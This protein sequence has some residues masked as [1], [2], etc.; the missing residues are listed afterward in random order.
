MRTHLVT[1]SIPPAKRDTATLGSSLCLRNGTGVNYEDRAKDKYLSLRYFWSKVANFSW[2]SSTLLKRNDEST[3]TE[4]QDF[5]VF[6]F[7][8][9]RP[10]LHKIEHVW[11]EEQYQGNKHILFLVL[12]KLYSE[13]NDII[14]IYAP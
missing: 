14:L 3:K 9:F 6:F 11:A 1:S 5:Y 7:L 4:K 2:Q 12:K 10:S 8:D 13:D